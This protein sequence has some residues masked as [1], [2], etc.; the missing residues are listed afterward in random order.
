[1]F[2]DGILGQLLGVSKITNKTGNMLVYKFTYLYVQI[3]KFQQN[4]TQR[5][6]IETIRISWISKALLTNYELVDRLRS[7]WRLPAY[8][9]GTL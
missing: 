4:N 1:M 7:T 5:I 3:S 6:I 8:H 9:I 2:V